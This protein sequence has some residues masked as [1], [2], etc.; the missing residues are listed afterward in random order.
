MHK[1][2]FTSF[3]EFKNFSEKQA[4]TEIIL[5]LGTVPLNFLVRPLLITISNFVCKNSPSY[6][7]DL[8]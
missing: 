3:L 6:K 2:G 7:P 4:Q 1:P 5:E 8:S